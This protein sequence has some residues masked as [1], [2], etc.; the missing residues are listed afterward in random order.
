MIPHCS[1]LIPHCSNWIPDCSDL[2]PYE[3]CHEI[4][5]LFVL[6]KLILQM[7][8]HSHPVG[9]RCLIFWC[10]LCLLPYFM[11]GNREDSGKTARMH[12]LA[13][14]GQICYLYTIISWA[15]SYYSNFK[16]ILG[17][18]MSRHMTKPTKGHVRPVWSESLLSAWRKCRSLATEWGHS[19]DS[20]QTG[21]MPRLIWVFVGRTV[22]LLVLSWGGSNFTDVSSV[23]SSVWTL[24]PWATTWVC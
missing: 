9:A 13:W 4:M 19:E 18:Q 23:C 15:G 16:I 20:D 22:T 6:R 3:P 7:R 5:V 24:E 17:I 1:N 11:C 2:I 10:T 12:R 8:M 14:A 21:R